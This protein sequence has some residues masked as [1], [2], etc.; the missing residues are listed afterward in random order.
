VLTAVQGTMNGGPSTC[1]YVS[2][3]VRVRLSVVHDQFIASSPSSNDSGHK[4]PVAREHG[5]QQL[6]MRD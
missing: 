5:G 1:T 2:P 4:K 3:N 6:L